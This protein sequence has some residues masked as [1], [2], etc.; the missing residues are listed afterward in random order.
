MDGTGKKAVQ[1]LVKRGGRILRIHKM[2]GVYGPFHSV[3]EAHLHRYLAEFDFRYSHRIALGIEDTMRA[4]EKLKA[5]S[6]KHLS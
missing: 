1:V 6:G 3:S 4:N 2:R 5:S